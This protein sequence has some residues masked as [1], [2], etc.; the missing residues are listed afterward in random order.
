MQTKHYVGQILELHDKA[1]EIAF[2]RRVN[3]K[4]L[5]FSF[6]NVSD[7]TTVAKNDVLQCVLPLEQKG[8][9]RQNHY[10][11]FNFEKPLKY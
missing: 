1:F 10:Y 9:A 5:T 2:L 11:T 4:S 6:P 8:T 7:V 3:N